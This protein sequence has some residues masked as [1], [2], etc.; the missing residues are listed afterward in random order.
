MSVQ[1]DAGQGDDAPRRADHRRVLAVVGRAATAAVVVRGQQAAVR[2]AT[3]GRG[4]ETRGTAAAA[5][6]IRRQRGRAPRGEGEGDQEPEDRI[7]LHRRV[8]DHDRRLGAV[9]ADGRQAVPARRRGRTGPVSVARVQARAPGHRRV[10]R[11][12]A[13]PVVRQT[14]AGPVAVPVRAAPVHAHR[15][16]DRPAGAPGVDVLDRLAVQE[17]AERRPVPG[18]RVAELRGGRVHRVQRLQRVSHSGQSGQEQRHHVPV[19]EERHRLHRRTP[20]QEPG[21]HQP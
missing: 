18:A 10:L 15:R 17:A 9:R 12:D 8:A 4:R 5:G 19:G 11:V 7:L 3:V 1:R 6:H 21:P 2:H 13:R 20:R 16:D 14:V